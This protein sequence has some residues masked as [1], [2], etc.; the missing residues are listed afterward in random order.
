MLVFERNLAERSSLFCAM[1]CAVVRIDITDSGEKHINIYSEEES[2]IL[3]VGSVLL[4]RVLGVPGTCVPVSVLYWHELKSPA[5]LGPGGPMA[6]LGPA[7][8]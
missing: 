4:A 8:P 7:A 5:P 6:P 2:A 1:R 3:T